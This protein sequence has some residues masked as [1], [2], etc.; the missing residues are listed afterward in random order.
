M[1]ILPKF[2]YVEVN[3][4]AESQSACACIEVSSPSLFQ[5]TRQIFLWFILITQYYLHK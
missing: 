5:S 4:L 1:S 2:I 3:C